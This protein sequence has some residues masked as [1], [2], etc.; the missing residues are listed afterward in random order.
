MQILG[1]FSA[2]AHLVVQLKLQ[3]GPLSVLVNDTCNAAG[4]A[5]SQGSGCYMPHTAKTHHSMSTCRRWLL[6][7]TA[8]VIACQRQ[9]D[10][11]S[12]QEA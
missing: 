10:L 3:V 2:A 6:Q 11:P 4:F 9:A 1:M 8:A 12:P 5:S 7:H